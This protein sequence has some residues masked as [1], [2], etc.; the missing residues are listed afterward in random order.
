M[1][2]S[3][4]SRSLRFAVLS[5]LMLGG[6][7]ALCVVVTPRFVLGANEGGV[8]NYG[9]HGS[10]VIPYTLA[11]VGSAGFLFLAGRG[12]R[13][14]NGFGR[15]AFGFEVVALMLV[16]VLV[17]TY[18]YKIDATLADVHL[19][20]AIL[21]FCAELPLVGGLAFALRSKRRQVMVWLAWLGALG[22]LSGAVIAVVTLL[23]FTHILFVGQAVMSAGFA[24]VLIASLQ[25]EVALLRHR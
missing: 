5:Q 1:S 15:A 11:F 20:A 10:T 23:G 7:L 24:V 16:V 17:S 22:W 3:L 4:M 12:L 19:G 8:S 9:V 14:T 2:G 21:L 18:P 13:Y 6:F 25:T